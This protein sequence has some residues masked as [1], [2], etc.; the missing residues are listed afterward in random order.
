VALCFAII[1]S[2]FPLAAA[3]VLA[4]AT[5]AVVG[6]VTPLVGADITQGTGRYSASLG[7]VQ[8][9]SL[10]GA[11]VST[12]LSGFAVERIGF[13]AT[14]FGLAAVALLGWAATWLLMP[15]TAQEAVWED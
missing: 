9:L 2:P 1:A 8:M 14:F 12:T 3:Q 7:T 4:G 10:I 11:A 5:T 15:E 6:I 13:V